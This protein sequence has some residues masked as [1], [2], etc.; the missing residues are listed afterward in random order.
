MGEAN[1]A[2]ANKIKYPKGQQGTNVKNYLAEFYKYRSNNPGST[3]HTFAKTKYDWSGGENARNAAK[4]SGTAPLAAANKLEPFKKS[5]GGGGKGGGG[6]A[7]I[8]KRK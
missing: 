1:K 3:G 7:G 2:K 8:F 4:A 5:K 6:L